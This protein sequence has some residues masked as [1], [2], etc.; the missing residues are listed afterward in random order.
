MVESNTSQAAEMVRMLPAINR[1][2]VTGT[3]DDLKPLLEFVGRTE[4]CRPPEAWQTVDK[5]FQLNFKPDPLLE[6]LE[7]S[8]WRTCKSKVEHELGIP[9]QTQV[10][11]RLELSNVESLYY[12]E[13]HLKCHEQF[14]AAVA[15]HTRHNADN[16]SCLAAIS[17]QLLRIILKPFLRI[18]QT[19]SVPVVLNSNV[20]SNCYLNPQE[21]L[22]RLKS[23][24]ESECKTELRSWASSYNGL[25]SIHFIREDF[26]QAIKYYK[27]LLKLAA[28][29]NEENIS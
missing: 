11:H 27:L 13:E 29:Y 26:A 18:R 17:P 1:W 12:R 19:C 22:A 4:A 21:L 20:A 24:N 9:P 10:V 15:K 7:H 3:I 2:A 28:D 5:A 6:V 14:L 8:L 25:A 16:S 23:N